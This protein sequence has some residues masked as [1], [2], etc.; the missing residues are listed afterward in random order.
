MTAAVP[1]GS[2]WVLPGLLLAGVYPGAGA[3]RR[4]SRIEALEAL[5]VDHYIDLTWPGELPPYEHELPG[6]Y[7][8]GSARPTHYSRRPIVDHGVPK[9]PL[10]TLEILDEIEEAI[11]AGHCVYVHCR[12]GIGRTGLVLGC[13]MAR[14]FRDGQ[15]ALAHLNRLWQASGRAADYPQTPET[16]EQRDYVLQW[17]GHDRATARTVVR[18]PRPPPPPDGSLPEP[19]DSADSAQGMISRLQDR[20]RGLLLG[21]ALGDALGQAAMHRRPGAGTPVGDLLG[22]GPH[23]MPPGAWTDD[24]AVP[25]LIADSLLACG[26]T[27]ARDQLDRLRRWQTQGYLSATGQCIGITAA[28]A[29]ALM[30]AQWTGN[31]YC[32]SHDPERAD[33]EPLVRAGVAIAW[34]LPDLELGVTTAVDA[35][36]LTHQAPV[37]L[38]AMRYLSA[39]LFG[40]LRGA[41]KAAILAPWYSP[42]ADYW[43]DQALKPE[44][45]AIAA[46]G[47]SASAPAVT[48]RAPDALAAALWALA[49]G[50]TFKDAVLRAANL[51]GEAD[52]TA[53]L[54]GALAG[55]VYGAAAIPAGWRAALH[56]RELIE[57]I[58]DRLLAAAVERPAAG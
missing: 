57:K 18:R 41:G 24:T 32:G 6:P 45:A 13:L 19:A 21:L 48:G 47:W 27:D 3:G 15:R 44:I 37:V 1:H 7:G 42:R 46:G 28:T 20:Y 30:H 10:Q 34:A 39:V 4:P 22:G 2:Y 52:N 33:Q 17:P 8:V 12:A 9:S 40:A 38:D 53:A 25:L 11:A 43:A 36:R 35:S 58:A 56:A 50:Q 55:A 16:E 14:R 54:A 5:G 26:Q 51:G 49:G 29:R 31:P 23:E